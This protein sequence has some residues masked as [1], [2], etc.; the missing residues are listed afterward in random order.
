MKKVSD[1]SVKKRAEQEVQRGLH[2]FFAGLKADGLIEEKTQPE[3]EY[4][5]LQELFAGLAY[6]KVSTFQQKVREV[7][8]VC[9]VS[10]GGRSPN[11]SGRIL[12]VL[13]TNI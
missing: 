11:M 3:V 1:A 8:K 7:R 13:R 4:D 5:G 6:G 9:R 12:A 2:E 10:G